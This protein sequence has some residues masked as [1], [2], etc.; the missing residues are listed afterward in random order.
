MEHMDRR[1][2]THGEPIMHFTMWD[3]KK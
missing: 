2:R 1:K 3:K